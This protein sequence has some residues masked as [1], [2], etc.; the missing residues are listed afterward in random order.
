MQLLPCFMSFSMGEINPAND[1]TFSE[2]G[3]TARPAAR[4]WLV[5]PVKKSPF[6]YPVVLAC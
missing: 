4:S 3:I 1:A 5:T 2:H 6:T